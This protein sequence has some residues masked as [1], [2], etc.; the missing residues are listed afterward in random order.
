M[1]R[2]TRSPSSF[3]ARPAVTAPRPR[4]KIRAHKTA[5][6]R[7]GDKHARCPWP[8]QAAPRPI[9]DGPAYPFDHTSI[10]ATVRKLFNLG[11]PLTARDRVAPDLLGALSL[12]L[13]TND[14]PA[15]IDPSTETPPVE[16]LQTR[17]AAPPN[18]MQA[19]LSAAAATLPLSPPATADTS[20]PR[21]WNR[22][23]C[24]RLARVGPD[25]M[26]RTKMFLGV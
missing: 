3:E 24:P 9:E 23:P 19:S 16:Q 26:T 20:R 8:T 13:P 6:P 12:A 17:A 7:E 4:P 11:E 5:P 2:G 21:P 1:R 22:R 25:A 14:G 10:I 18:G 15:R